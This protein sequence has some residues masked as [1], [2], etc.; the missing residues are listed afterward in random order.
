MASFFI[1]CPA[2]R[3]SNKNLGTHLQSQ[4]NVKSL[5]K[6]NLVDHHLLFI[7]SCHR[8]I[9]KDGKGHVK[10]GTAVFAFFSDFGFRIDVLNFSSCGIPRHSPQ[11]SFKIQFLILLSNCCISK[12]TR[13]SG[14]PKLSI[15]LWNLKAKARY[16]SPVSKNEERQNVIKKLL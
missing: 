7:L 3:S 5:C 4:Q 9:E 8:L 10:K 1:K 13:D 11:F 6:G 2:W 16:G 14:R 15:C 12:A